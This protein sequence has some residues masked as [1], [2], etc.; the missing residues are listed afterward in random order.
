MHIFIYICIYMYIQKVPYKH[1][2]R[3][4][5]ANLQYIYIFLHMG[6]IAVNYE[7]VYELTLQFTVNNA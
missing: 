1:I 5:E 7:I 2:L 4:A 6:N 3:K